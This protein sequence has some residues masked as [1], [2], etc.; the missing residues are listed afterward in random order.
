MNPLIYKMVKAEK[1]L[2]ENFKVGDKTY[3]VKCPKCKKENYAHSVASG[4]CAWCGYNAN[5][6]E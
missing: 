6:E 4:V 3:L 2:E 5:E 1:E